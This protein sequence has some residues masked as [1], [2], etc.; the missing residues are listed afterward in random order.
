MTKPA[1]AIAL[2]ALTGCADLDVWFYQ[3]W[4]AGDTRTANEKAKPDSPREPA[5]GDHTYCPRRS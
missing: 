4:M 2:A 1:L 5:H 3:R